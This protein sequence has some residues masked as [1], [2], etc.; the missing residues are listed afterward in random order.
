MVLHDSAKTTLRSAWLEFGTGSAKNMDNEGGR[1]FFFPGKVPGYENYFLDM[2]KINPEY[3]KY[4]DR[5]I[6]HL[7]TNVFVPFIEVSR[8]DA[9]LLWYKY[10][11]WPESYSRFIQ[12]IFPR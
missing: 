2:D 9:G 5:K 11:G 1:P 12:Y 7:N 6:A 4:L 3:F 8:R 10:Y